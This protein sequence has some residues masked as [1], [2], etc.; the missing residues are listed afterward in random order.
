MISFLKVKVETISFHFS[1]LCLDFLKSMLYLFTFYSFSLNLNLNFCLF[2]YASWERIEYQNNIIWN[3]FTP[4]AGQPQQLPP[5][6]GQLQLGPGGP[7]P[8]NQL[9]GLGNHHHHQQGLAAP[10]GLGGGAGGGGGALNPQH[11]AV[12]RELLGLVSFDDQ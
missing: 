9:Q 4:G 1:F 3:L 5:D 12:Q 7:G 8:H 6:I 11:G 2:L 10:G